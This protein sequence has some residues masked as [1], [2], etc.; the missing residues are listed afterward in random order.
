RLVTKQALSKYERGLI[1]PSAG[2]AERLALALGVKTISLCEEPLL[3][4]K[5]IAY[6][7]EHGLRKKEKMRVENLVARELEKRIRMQNLLQPLLGEM[8]TLPKFQVK[9]LEEVEEATLQIRKDWNLG[10]DP[11]ASVTGL[12]EDRLVHVMEIEVEDKRF[13]GLSVVAQDAKNKPPVAAMVVN[14]KGVC[15]ERQRSLLH[16]LAH[17]VLEISHELEEERAAFFFAS[18]L[19]APKSALYQKIGIRRKNIEAE[20]LLLHKR[21]FGISIQALLYRLMDLNI[22]NKSYFKSW[23]REINRRGWKI[24]EPNESPSEEPTWLRRNLLRA[25]SEGIIPR[26]APTENPGTPVKNKTDI[27][28]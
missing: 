14:R 12:L 25:Q 11:I 13:D 3:S 6:R 2:V 24:E 17:L 23:S 20:E 18:A 16:E 10:L 15:G 8:F 21:Y 28:A 26:T 7:L 27:Y 4:Y 22:I 19:L 1:K 9:I 5:S